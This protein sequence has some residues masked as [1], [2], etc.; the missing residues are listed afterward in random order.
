MRRVKELRERKHL[1]LKELEERSGVD[2]SLIN[3]IENGKVTPR[4]DTAL[5][6]ARALGVS[7]SE[8]LKDYEY[9]GATA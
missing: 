2:G 3:R 8:L 4:V 9:E 1:T 5:K 7:V 6:L